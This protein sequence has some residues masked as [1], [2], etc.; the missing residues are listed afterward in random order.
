MLTNL[1]YFFNFDYETFA[2]IILH[3]VW[4]PGY[5]RVRYKNGKTFVIV[6][7]VLENIFDR[8]SILILS[9]YNI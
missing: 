1:D 5:F 8:N 4:I 7:E 2:K 9:G 6:Q 3:K